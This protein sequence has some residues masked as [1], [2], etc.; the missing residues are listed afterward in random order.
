MRNHRFIGLFRTVP[1]GRWHVC[2][3]D[4]PGCEIEG[5]SFKEVFE[6]SRRALS[7]HLADLDDPAPRPRSTAEL[8]IDAQRDARLCR[9]LAEAVMH[10]VEPAASD[11]LAPLALVAARSRGGNSL[12]P[13]IGT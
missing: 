11:G 4:L 2:F 3:P 7:E 10:P 5:R 8:L 13:Q 6:E 9:L 12:P 1:H